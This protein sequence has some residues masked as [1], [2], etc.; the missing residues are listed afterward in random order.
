MEAELAP[1]LGA[2]F[3]ALQV[4]ALVLILTR[5]GVETQLLRRHGDHLAGRES[6]QAV[7]GVDGVV[8]L[9]NA[10]HIGAAHEEIGGLPLLHG[11][12][13]REV[14]DADISRVRREKIRVQL[15]LRVLLPVGSG[16]E[17][18]GAAALAL[19]CLAVLKSDLLTRVGVLLGLYELRIGEPPNLLLSAILKAWV[20]SVERVLLL[21][22]AARVVVA[23]LYRRGLANALDHVERRGHL[24]SLPGVSRLLAVGLLELVRHLINM[25]REF[26]AVVGER[27]P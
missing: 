9:L 6:L 8:A 16:W 22:G 18:A 3:N 24:A 4:G 1:G 27:L 19:L 26:A 7:L 12:G 23:G 14:V 11:L 15:P 20:L 2:C 13:R 25:L 17:L 21:D 10:L 5:A